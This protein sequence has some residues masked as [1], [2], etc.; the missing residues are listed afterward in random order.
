MDEVKHLVAIG[1]SAGGIEGVKA[2]IKAL[3]EDFVSPIV[4]VLHL[5][6]SKETFLVELLGK[7]CKLKVKEADNQEALQLATVYVAPRNYHLLLE[8]DLRFSLSVDDPVNFS[9]PSVDV[10]FESAA[11]VMGPRLTGVIL[12]GGNADGAI[13]LAKIKEMGGTTVVQDPESV[14]FSAMPEAAIRVTEVDF[15]LPVEEI[16]EKLVELSAANYKA[17][18]MDGDRYA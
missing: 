2:I 1:A 7:G 10:F 14:R 16:A 9:R 3:P 15:V 4:V 17:G 13:G 5:S 8:D 12:S 18:F 6:R 11:D